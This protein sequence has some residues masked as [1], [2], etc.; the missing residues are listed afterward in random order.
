[1]ERWLV[2]GAAGF[3]GNNIVRKLLADGHQVTGLDN[4][5]NG[6][7]SNVED[8]EADLNFRFVEGDIRDRDLCYDLCSAVDYVSHQA[9]MGSVPRSIDTPDIS[10]DNNVNGFLNMLMAARDYGLRLVYASS[11]SVYGDNTELPKREDMIGRPLSPYAATKQI[12]EMYADVFCRVYD[13]NAVGLRY[14]NVFGPYQKFSGPYVTVIPTWARAL[15]KGEPVIIYGDGVTSRDFCYVDDVVQ[16]N[17]LAAKTHLKGSSIF[18]VGAGEQ[19]SLVE[20]LNKLQ[21]IYGTDVEPQFEDFRAG[22]TRHTLADISHGK[23]Q[24]GYEPKFNID[25]GLEIATAWYKEVI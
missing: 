20:L 1:M 14:F 22:D 9:A 3:I 12:N 24:L 19:T 7:R 6:V 8:L 17:I 5:S 21:T 18:N 15:L 2:T 23:M 13:M 4:F 16:M 11:G 25:S 10:N